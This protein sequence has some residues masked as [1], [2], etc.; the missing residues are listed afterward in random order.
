[1]THDEV[2]AELGTIAHSGTKDF[3]RALQSK[4]LKDKPELIGQFGVGFYSSFMV[5]DKV[6]VITRKATEKTKK[7]VKWESTADGS[8][9]IDE[10]EKERAGTDVVLHLKSEDKNYLNEWEIRSIIRKYSDYIEHPVVMDVEREKE[11]PLDKNKKI[12]VTEE[13]TMNAGKAIWLKDPSEVN[14]RGI[15]RVLQAYLPRFRRSRKGHPL[16]RRGHV[17]VHRAALC[18]RKGPLRDPVQGLQDRPD[19]VCQ[20]G[21]DHGPLRTAHSRVSALCQGRGR[22]LGPSAERIARDPA[23]QQARRGHQEEHHQES[24]RYPGGHEK[25]RLRCLC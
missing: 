10:A 3:L 1:M 2:I 4:E 13:E 7:A 12:K 9:T 6:T 24:A 15:Q 14:G 8:F 18:S 19:P 16:P 25:E 17:G 23:V 5:A 21:P 20:A 22:L 11:D